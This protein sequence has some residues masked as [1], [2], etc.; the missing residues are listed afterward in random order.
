MSLFQ[1]SGEVLKV[2]VPYDQ[3]KPYVLSDI[4]KHVQPTPGSVEDGGKVNDGGKVDD[5]GN[6][7]DGGKSGGGGKADVII[8]SER[9]AKKRAIGPLPVHRAM[10]ASELPNLLQI[11]ENGQWLTDEHI[12]NAQAIL[13]KHFP[14]IGGLQAAWVFI[15]EGCHS[16]GTP[17]EDFVQILN[18]GGNHW[19]TVSN[20]GNPKDTITIYDSLY[21]GVS[22]SCKAKFTKQMAFM[23][24][25]T[26]KHVTL[27][28]A[29]MQKQTGSSD[30]GL[31]AIAAAT[32]L[33]YDVLP[34]DCPWEQGKMQVHLSTCFKLV[35][36]TLF[37]QSSLVRRHRSYRRME[38]VEVF[39]HC[40]QP[41]NKHAFM[42]Q[43]DS[44]KDWFH[45]GC[46][47]IPRKMN[48]NTTFLCKN[49]K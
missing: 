2:K 48:K 21:D 43:C 25:A 31:F 24:M 22:C 7:D 10:F 26:S 32:S 19:I 13:A 4:H 9:K 40:R 14:Y 5:G 37:P 33:C 1:K 11:N 44:C 41:N 17:K 49:C 29:D 34:Q 46:Q 47:R 28:Q 20:V 16:I 30:C 8:I 15:S 18:V 35:D 23:L 12:D 38:K 3:I 27:Q 45:R 6:V 36:L 42:V 39:C